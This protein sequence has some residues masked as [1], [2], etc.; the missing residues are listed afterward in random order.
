MPGEQLPR[1]SPVGG[2]GME[3]VG[4]IG[5]R[6]RQG[7]QTLG[8]A[9]RELRAEQL[10]GMRAAD[11]ENRR[12]IVGLI[13]ARFIFAGFLGAGPACRK[14][15]EPNF[16]SAAGAAKRADFHQRRGFQLPHGGGQGGVVLIAGHGPFIGQR[17]SGGAAEHRRKHDPQ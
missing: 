13:F 6:R 3:L 2:R 11:D 7:D 5:R 4:R 15:E 9:D 17:G 12:L 8:H 10:R 16:A 14:C 1:A